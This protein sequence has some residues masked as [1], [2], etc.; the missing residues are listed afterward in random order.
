MSLFKRPLI[1]FIQYNISKE[2]KFWQSF[3]S[4]LGPSR[5]Y[6]HLNG[7][8]I[9][10]TPVFY[11]YSILKF[12]CHLFLFNYFPEY[13]CQFCFSGIVIFLDGKY[14]FFECMLI[15]RFFKNFLKQHR[16]MTLRSRM[17]NIICSVFRRLLHGCPIKMPAIVGGHHRVHV[18]CLFF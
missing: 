13:F 10:G 11:Q 2:R 8:P 9:Q 14:H 4:F 6:T 16:H 3:Y 12:F 15:S 7:V 17:Q 1:F 5:S 18:Q